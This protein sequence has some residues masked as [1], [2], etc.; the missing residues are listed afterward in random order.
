MMGRIARAALSVAWL[1]GCAC[2]QPDQ[3]LGALTQQLESV[4]AFCRGKSSEV[5]PECPL[6]AGLLQ[7]KIVAVT[8]P[9]PPA[10]QPE[11]RTAEQVAAIVAR[12]VDRD[13]EWEL[14]ATGGRVPQNYDR[15][16]TFVLKS[17]ALF[18]EPGLDADTIQ[19]RFLSN[20]SRGVICGARSPV[21]MLGGHTETTPF[22]AYFDAGGRLSKIT[23]PAPLPPERIGA[24]YGD[25][26]NG[27][28]AASDEAA[29]LRI[30]G[31]IPVS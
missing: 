7:A 6:N 20:P 2:P 17:A 4:R 23:E 26:L 15:A 21:N 5:Y 3:E 18:R 13:R 9:Q 8:T 30:C 12:S 11:T 16:I 14:K 1:G 31:I 24:M 29:L 22:A 19:I 27:V 28:L 10:P 25:R